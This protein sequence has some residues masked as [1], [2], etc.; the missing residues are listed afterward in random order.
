VSG[1]Q[2]LSLNADRQTASSE[3]FYAAA[4][5]SDDIDAMR[6]I[7]HFLKDHAPGLPTGIAVDFGAGRGVMAAAAASFFT[8]SWALDLSIDVLKR[9]ADSYS[10]KNLHV[11]DNMA[12]LPASVDVV[13]AWHT[14]E[15]LPDALGVMTSLADRL[16]PQGALFWQVPIY[17]PEYVVDTH[18]TFFNEFSARS[19]CERAGLSFTG[20]WE[21]LA[22]GFITV[23]ARKT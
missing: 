9:C 4:P 1:L 13:I 2:D 17:R 8:E 22:N 5:T 14:I 12:D 18:F 10:L 21:D 20:I 3:E 23:L 16:A 7:L 11:T 15:H 19:I 6:S